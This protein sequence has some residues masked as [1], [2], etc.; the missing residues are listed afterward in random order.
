LFGTT[1]FQ[2]VGVT[3]VAIAAVLVLLLGIAERRRLYARI[4]RDADMINRYV[5]VINLRNPFHVKKWRQSVEIAANGDCVIR[6]E[7]I[8]SGQRRRA[9]FRQAEFDLLRVGAVDRPGPAAG[10]TLRALPQRRW[11]GS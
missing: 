10:Q 11:K 6:I 7:Q 1:W 3:M 4:E 9:A 5:N 2:L 8:L